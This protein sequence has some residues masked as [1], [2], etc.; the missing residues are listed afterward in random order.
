[1]ERVNEKN[2]TIQ[3]YT[4]LSQHYLESARLSLDKELYEPALFNAIHA[5]ELSLKAALFSKTTQLWKTHNIGGEFGK[6][7]KDHIGPDICRKINIILS[8]YNQSRYPG[9]PAIDPE[10]V[11][12][13]IKRI[14][15]IIE[16]TI[17]PLIDSN[18]SN[19]QKNEK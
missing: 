11:E 18:M 14:K 5:L 10:E 1:M 19:L 17:L 3:E 13:N 2:E 6:H 8:K 15:E 9:Q 7:F 12:E 4:K 16:E